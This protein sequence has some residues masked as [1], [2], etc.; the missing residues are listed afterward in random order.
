MPTIWMSPGG[1][2][3]LQARTQQLGEVGLL[4]GHT[5][6]VARG[7]NGVLRLGLGG[8]L[9]PAYG[10]AD[11]HQQQTEQRAAAGRR[12]RALGRT[13]AA[14]LRAAAR[15]ELG[16]VR[17]LDAGDIAGDRKNRSA[18]GIRDRLDRR[19]HAGRG[20]NGNGAQDAHETNNPHSTPPP[21][22]CVQGRRSRLDCQRAERRGLQPAAVCCDNCNLSDLD[23]ISGI[24]AAHGCKATALDAIRCVCQ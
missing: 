14:T 3:R 16:R 11:R 22:G 24:T 2:R 4:D 12:C 18:R 6:A 1:L 5:Q 10:R 7:V 13:H 8:A 19:L 15:T 20:Q 21:L 17:I 23:R 9:G